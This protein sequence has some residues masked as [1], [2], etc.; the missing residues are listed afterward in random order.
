MELCAAANI[1]ARK[2]GTYENN[3]IEL[4]SLADEIATST[5]LRYEFV[6]HKLYCMVAVGRDIAEI[7]QVVSTWN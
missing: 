1:L 6:V 2:L 7:K 3:L 5:T 4:V